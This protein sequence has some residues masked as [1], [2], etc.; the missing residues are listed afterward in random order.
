MMTGSE[1]ILSS[2]LQPNG[3]TPL[4]QQLLEDIRRTI[5]TGEYKSGEKIPSEPELSELYS[6]SRITVRRAVDELCA[7]GYLIKKQGK[8]TYVGQPKIRRKMEAEDAQSFTDVCNNNGMK[9]T[10]KVTNIQHIPASQTDIQVL[11]LAP[12][13]MMLYIQ[14][15]HSA[16][17]DPI[18]IENNYYPLDRFGFLEKEDLED[19]SLFHLLSDKYGI[20]PFGT[21]STR[22][23]VVRASAKNAALLNVK[24]GEPL[25]HVDACFK[26][27]NNVNIFIGKQYIVGNRYVMVL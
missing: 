26:D 24:V 9:H 25:L 21:S 16:D 18:M 7:E 19:G 3:S 14:R 11:G 2:E 5:E 23:E 10:V 22:I 27:R 13:A 17:G 12:G 4:Y 1:I 20:N 8:G 6:V 15:V